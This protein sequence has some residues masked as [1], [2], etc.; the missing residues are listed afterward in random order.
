MKRN[1]SRSQTEFKIWTCQRLILPK[2]MAFQLKI[3]VPV[4]KTTRYQYPRVKAYGKETTKRRGQNEKHLH[5]KHGKSQNEIKVYISSAKSIPAGP[6][7]LLICL[8]L[9]IHIKRR[10]LTTKRTNATSL[11]HFL[12]IN[13]LVLIFHSRRRTPCLIPSVQTGNILENNEYMS[14]FLTLTT[15]RTGYL[16]EKPD[17]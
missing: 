7:L 5:L 10:I 14:S 12:P 6:I 15:S 4:C 2:I 3:S 1:F 16:E 9:T 17:N 13:K 8:F 11:Q